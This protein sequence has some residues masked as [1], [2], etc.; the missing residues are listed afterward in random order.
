MWNL[1]ETGITTAAMPV[2][3][4]TA[5]GKKQIGQIASAERGLLVKFVGSINGIGA[6]VSPIFIYP[7]VR[8]LTE[9]LSE[10]SPVGSIALGNKFS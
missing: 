3:E 4:V 6:M 9:Y 1:D 10:V 8:N 7:R 5:K 2:K